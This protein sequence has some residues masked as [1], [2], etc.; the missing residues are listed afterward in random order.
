MYVIH[1]Y[2]IHMYVIHASLGAFSAQSC[3]KH[4][5]CSTQTVPEQG[6]QMVYFQAKNRDLGKFWRVSQW[7]ML[8][9]FMVIWSIFRP[10]DIFYGHL[11]HLIGG[12]LSYF[13]PVSVCCARKNLATRF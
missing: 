4:R 2:A 8:V 7:K 12:N 1:M 5:A 13:P 10:F 6:C 11:V 9:H 3:R